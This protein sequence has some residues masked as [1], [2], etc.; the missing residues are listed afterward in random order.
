MGENIGSKEKNKTNGTM[1]QV[2]T[3]IL[4]VLIT[5]LIIYSLMMSVAIKTDVGAYY[6]RIDKIQTRIDSAYQVNKRLDLKLAKLDS[7]ISFLNDEIQSVEKN[8]NIIKKRTNEQVVSVDTFSNSE[9]E[10]FFSKRYN[11]NISK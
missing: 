11:P 6:K 5:G 3:N 10:E 7:N 8:I 1:K 2:L 9:L 4:L